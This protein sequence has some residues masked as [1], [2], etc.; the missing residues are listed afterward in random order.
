M[1]FEAVDLYRTLDLMSNP[2]DSSHFRAYCNFKRTINCPATWTNTYHPS[3]Q[4]TD[5]R[6]HYSVT[7]VSQQ[8]RSNHENFSFIIK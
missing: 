2:V 6:Y 3:K 5:W 8:W 1:F 7:Y 4:R